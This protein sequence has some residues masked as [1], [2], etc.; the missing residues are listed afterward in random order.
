MYQDIAS[1]GKQFQAISDDP[2]K[3]SIILGLRSSLKVSETYV[4]TAENVSGWQS[5]NEAAFQQLID[6]ATKADGLV[7]RGSPDT[8][9]ASERAAIGAQLEA[10]LKEAVD[11]A[12]STWSGKYIFSGFQ[13]NKAPFSFNAAQTAVGYNGDHGILTQEISLGQ[14]LDYGFDGS[15][16]FSDFFKA[17]L[18]ASAAMKNNDLSNINQI[19]SAMAVAMNTIQLARS[20][21]G[22]NQK[23]VN[24]TL[25]SLNS[26]EL[27]IKS[28]L[29]KKEDAN[30][31]E[32]ISN[33]KGQETIYQTVIEVSSRAIS[34]LNLFQVMQ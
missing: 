18:E 7:T 2:G 34:A 15:A 9:S 3:A 30:M 23:Q 11:G 22:S 31:A 19:H 14:K 17:L 33:L 5:A 26:T 8:Q 10:L 1:S 28:L 13:T 20:T 21:N 27:E 16:V 6:I 24:S 12:N 25:E 4:N 32:A 29:S